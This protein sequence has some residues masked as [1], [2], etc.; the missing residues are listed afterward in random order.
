MKV[1]IIFGIV[2]GFRGRGEHTYLL[3]CQIV[4]CMIQERSHEYYGHQCIMVKDIEDKSNTLSSRCVFKRTGNGMRYPVIDINDPNDRIAAIIRYLKKVSPLQ[5][6]FYCKEASNKQRELMTRNGYPLA[7]MSPSQPYGENT[8]GAILKEGCKKC[9]LDISGHG[10]R[11][12]FVTSLANHPGLSMAEILA[13]TRHSS[14]A[15]ILPYQMRNKTSEAA[16]FAAIVGPT[17]GKRKKD[18]EEEEE[19][20]GN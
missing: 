9:G 1:M 2:F 8:I 16:K 18:N 4:I 3:V 14:V 5:L 19:K 6:R 7:E 17:L 11:R 15:A 10:L 13:A 20:D 12:I